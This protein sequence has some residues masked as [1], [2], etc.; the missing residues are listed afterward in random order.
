MTQALLLLPGATGP[1]SP[2]YQCN[3][4]CD[5]PLFDRV[6]AQGHCLH[7]YSAQRGVT[8]RR[9][10]TAD[11]RSRSKNWRG[12]IKGLP[13][14]L[15]RASADGRRP[16]RTSRSCVRLT[17]RARRLDRQHHQVMKH[18]SWYVCQLEPD[19]HN[20]NRPRNLK[21][22]PSSAKTPTY[23]PRSLNRTATAPLP[24]SH[25]P[26]PRPPT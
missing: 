15:Q 2:L 5:L 4:K 20:A 16:R 13:R 21:S 12:R 9:K 11:N 22:P 14:R 23:K 7:Q 3:R 24:Q 18:K 19:N 10:S 26:S 25:T 17:L 8:P 1:D 6:R